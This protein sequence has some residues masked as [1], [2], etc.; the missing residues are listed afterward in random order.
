MP[1]VEVRFNGDVVKDRELQ[2]LDYQLPNIVAAR[3]NIPS[4]WAFPPDAVTVDFIDM[5]PEAMADDEAEPGNVPVP[6]QVMSSDIQV[7][8]HAA[9]NG[10]RLVVAN[11]LAQSILTAI[12]RY[13]P[14]ECGVYVWLQ[15]HPGGYAERPR[16]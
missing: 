8:V 2:E 7:I 11:D 10:D 3:L 1:L 6:R 14:V 16:S 4:T 12:V 5:W 9:H 13:V 15:L